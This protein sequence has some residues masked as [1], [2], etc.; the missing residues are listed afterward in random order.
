VKILL[1]FA[2][3]ASLPAADIAVGISR[4]DISPP[5][6]HAMAGYA[7]RKQLSTGVHDPLYATVLVLKAAGQSIAIVT[8]DLHSGH[9]A[10][11]ESEAAKRFGIAHVLLAC[12]HTHAGPVTTAPA[13]Y[14]LQISN[15]KFGDD[16]PWWRST[17]DKL[18]AAVGE[19]AS[20]AA[21]ARLGVGLGSVY[22]GHNRRRVLPDSKVEM[23]WRNAEKV[24]TS[25][26]DPEITILR[27]D[28]PDGTPRAILVNYSCHP[29]VLG[30]DNLEISADYVGAMRA[31][32][33]KKF[34]GATV[35]FA[36]GAIGDINPYLD[37]QPMNDGPWEAVR[38]TGETLGEAVAKVMP[39]IK[40][41]PES[42]LQFTSKLHTFDHRFN[43]GEHVNVAMGV[44]ML[45]DAKAAT[46][47][48]SISG[49][50]FVE[51]QIRLRDRDDCAHT[52]LFSHTSTLG[53]PHMRYLPTIR[54][55]SEGGYGADSSTFI[56]PG[57][58]EILVDRAI[59]QLLKFQGRLKLVPD[60]RY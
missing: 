29:T 40:T 26:V 8:A 31:Y 51:H 52:L 58:G 2:L 23:F 50:P 24:P 10:R 25:P 7:A 9:S 47:F 35:L 4:V 60:L 54:A 36:N 53:T 37:K 38:W 57:A 42:K 17:E 22:I 45:G 30:P 34:P 5:T 16:D 49:D 6:G 32:V 44:G 56:E 33:E 3:A 1:S 43:A 14:G 41:A 20:K 46:C 21:P 27:V 28:A 13:A 12:S 19:A 15:L 18:I 11:L 59:V 39:R 48:V 55:A